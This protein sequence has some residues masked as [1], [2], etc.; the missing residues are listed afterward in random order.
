MTKSSVRSKSEVLMLKIK[1]IILTARTAKQRRGVLDDQK[2]PSF[3]QSGSGLTWFQKKRSNQ[4]GP[5]PL[6]CL[7]IIRNVLDLSLY[8]Q[9]LVR[10]G[11]ATGSVRVR[12]LVCYEV[13]FDRLRH[14]RQFNLI[15]YSPNSLLLRISDCCIY[16]R[17]SIT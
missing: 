11:F 9:S 17:I 14:Q 2:E 15:S 16:L 6:F 3:L 7:A 1:P 4:N 12:V 8:F 13:K 5:F 10:N